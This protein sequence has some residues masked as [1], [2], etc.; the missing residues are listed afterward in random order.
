MPSIRQVLL[1]EGKPSVS[2]VMATGTTEDELLS[3]AHTL[4]E[5]S[6]HPIAKAIVGHAKAKGLNALQGE[7]FRNIVGKGVGAM[8]GAQEYF[9]GNLKLFQE[10]DNPIGEIESQINTFQHEGHTIVIVGTHE[11]VLGV[12]TVADSVRETSV[13]AVRDL[14]RVGISQLVMLTGDNEGT[15]KKVAAQTGSIVISLTYYR[16]TR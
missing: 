15:A 8:I 7:K 5:Y 2:Q 1:T 14:H 3:I 10:L 12:I 13:K 16:K 4:E 11:K 9:A 6:T